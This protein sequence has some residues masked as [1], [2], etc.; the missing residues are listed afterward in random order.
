MPTEVVRTKLARLIATG[1]KIK[2]VTFR[3]AMYEIFQDAI[4][5]VRRLRYQHMWTDSLCI[6]QDNEDDW[7][8]EALFSQGVC[9]D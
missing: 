1:H 2:Y 5:L 3:H 4:E 7:R 6:I 8:K 9:I